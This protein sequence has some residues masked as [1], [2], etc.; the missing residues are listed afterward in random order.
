MVSGRLAAAQFGGRQTLNQVPRVQL[1][2]S[3]ILTTT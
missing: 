1:A 2:A 3:L